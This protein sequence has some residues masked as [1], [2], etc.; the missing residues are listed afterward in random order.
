MVA[1]G[2][3]PSVKTAQPRNAPPA[4]YLGSDTPGWGSGAPRRTQIQQRSNP[5][6][7]SPSY[8]S[9]IRI[10]FS[11]DGSSSVIDPPP[12]STQMASS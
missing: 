7:C 11:A 1:G 5:A 9:K 2:G 8:H 4:G 3:A 12:H 10:L 6:P